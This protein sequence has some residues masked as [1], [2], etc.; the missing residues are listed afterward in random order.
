MPGLPKV[1]RGQPDADSVSLGSVHGDAG[2][3]DHKAQEFDPLSME[4]TLFRLGVQIVLTQMFQDASD[5]DLMIFQGIGEDED[6]VE[7]DHY[8]DVSHVSEDVIHEGL[9]C[10]RRIGEPHGHNQEF[11]RAILGAKCCLPLMASGD[12]NIVVAG[13]QVELGVDLGTAEL[14]KEIGD[15][16][17]RGPIL[18]GELVEVPEVNAES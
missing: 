3:S 18:P 5:M 4:Q 7:V 8:E 13:P 15:K 16:W 10:S 2:G 1:S 17:D 6:I 11:E 12:V 14:V 9:E